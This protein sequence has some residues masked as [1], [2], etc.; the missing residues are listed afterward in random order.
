M[1][2]GYI[3]PVFLVITGA[4]LIVLVATAIVNTRNVNVNPKAAESVQQVNLLPSESVDISCAS[5]GKLQVITSGS[6]NYKLT[7]TGVLPS[8]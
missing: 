6:A 7:C 3:S 2:K 4:F 8:N 5:G 1:N